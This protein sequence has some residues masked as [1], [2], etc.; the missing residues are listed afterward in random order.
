MG[1]PI[2]P[3]DLQSKWLSS[4][5]RDEQGQDDSLHDSTEQVQDDSLHDSTK[6]KQYAVVMRLLKLEHM[7]L[8]TMLSKMP[9]GRLREMLSDFS[10]AFGHF[11]GKLAGVQDERLPDL[12][13]S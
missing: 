8:E 13:G 9:A 6:R 2:S 10:V 12:T 11:L 5:N 7:G 3:S 4:V 1:H